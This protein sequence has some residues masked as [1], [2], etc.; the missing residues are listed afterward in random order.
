MSRR[1]LINAL[2]VGEGGGRTYIANVLR[3]LSRDNRGFL[4]SLVAAEGALS[5][6]E[7]AG[8]P[9]TNVRLPKTPRPARP[10][11]RI[12][13]EQIA[14]P[15]RARKFDL[16][17]CIGDLAPVAG[18]TK[19]VVA[20]RNL[21][22]YDRTYYDTPR[23]RLLR[24]MV[25]A[26]VR[27]ANRIVVPTRAAASLIARE[28]K[29]SPNRFSVVPHGVSGEFAKQGE[30]AE[31][32]RPY[33]F[34]PASVERHKNIE[35]LLRA[36]ALLVDDDSQLLIAGGTET[37]PDYAN[38]LRSLVS[39]LGLDQRVVFLGLVP[40]S[41]IAALYRGAIALVFPSLLETFG[42]PLVEA[43]LLGTPAVAADI[44]AFREIAGAAAQFFPPNDPEALAVIL[45][46]LRA[47]PA[48]A[49]PGIDAG[50]R[51]AQDFSWQRSV[52][53]LCEVFA[54]A[55]EG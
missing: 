42:H 17:Y 54:E 15:V 37:D 41:R 7:T 50:R 34:L 28:L 23:L 46:R 53:D 52:D 10:L 38:H 47:D 6:Q 20:L 39:D 32:E 25:G 12:L 55:L 1:V 24:T 22:I 44:P 8:V 16:M 36:L 13:Y 43:M 9:V 51:R 3:E 29:V 14:L 45:R 31:P 30:R 26:G 40:Y 19:I 2:S 33:F 11:A 5:A 48:S 49:Q 18:G 35:V 21:N 27:R 4:F